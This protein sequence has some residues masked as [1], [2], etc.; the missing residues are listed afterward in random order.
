MKR[1]LF[2]ISLLLLLA[3]STFLGAF[4]RSVDAQTA[5]DAYTAYKLNMR[6]GPGTAFEIIAALEPST[7]LVLEARNGDMSWLL[8]Q[9]VDGALRG[10]VA[11]LYLDYQAGF[12]AT[13]L[14][15][16][17]ETMAFAPQAVG[18]AQPADNGA[19]NPGTA[20]ALP[21]SGQAP[22]L[23]ALPIVPTM[24]ANARA[25]FQR[26]QALGNNANVVTKIGECNSM[27]YAFLN[28]FNTG[29]YELGRYRDLQ[30]VI[31]SMRFVNPS[32][33]TGAG[34]TASTVLE[35]G[36]GNPSVCGALSPLECEYRQSRPSVAFIMLGMHD[37]HFL[38]GQQYESA[39]RT[40]IETSIEYGVIPVLTTFPIWPEPDYRTEA[41]FAFNAT[42]VRL[43]REYDVPLM[44]YW[45][46][47]QS[48]PHSGVGEDHVHITER[49]DSWTAFTGDE[50]QYGMT[51]WNLVALQTLKQIQQTVLH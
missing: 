6:T 1:R 18:P 50:Q 37:V 51:M 30:P 29:Q 14:P 5:P 2:A 15:L 19:E 35:G 41:R 16:S 27:S 32:Q 49:G 9:T 7:G 28:P 43:A 38:D 24:T 34:F 40:I 31:A 12:S 39:M 25:I 21:P 33:A 26:G 17:D 11:S 45:C 22:A 46:A 36:Y 42:L 4:F 44:N 10:W 8:A 20:G 23:E 48:I 13:R 47:A 3:T